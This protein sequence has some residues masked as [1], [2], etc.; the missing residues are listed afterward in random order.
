MNISELLITVLIAFGIGKISE[1]QSPRYYDLET[2]DG[3]VYSIIVERKS[4]YAC[5]LYCKAD[6]YHNVIIV[7][8]KMNLTSDFYNLFGFGSDNV[9]INSYE[10]ANL[11][12]VKTNDDKK[13]AKLK[14][15]DV[16]TYLP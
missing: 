1:H 6:H 13:R 11:E 16:Q 4:K 3:N 7:E 9:Y 5:P 10:V 14:R 8:D 15:L 12:E 2:I